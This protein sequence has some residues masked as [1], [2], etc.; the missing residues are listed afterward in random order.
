ME[1][2]VPF[3]WLAHIVIVQGKNIKVYMGNQIAFP[4]IENIL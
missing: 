1:P 3:L 4:E 2:C